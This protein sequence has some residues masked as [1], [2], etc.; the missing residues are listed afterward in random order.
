MGVWERLDPCSRHWWGLT[1][2]TVFSFGHLGTERMLR[3]WSRSKEGQRGLWWAWKICPLRRDWR[4]W[5][6]LVW[7]S[8]GWGETLLVFQYLK[9]A[10]SESGVGLFWLVTGW[11]EM[12][13]SCTRGGL[14]W[15]SGNTSL[16]KGLLSTGMGSPGRCLKTIPG[17]VSKPFWCGAQ[18]HDLAVGC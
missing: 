8:G 10:Y 1:L 16:Q 13:S 7:G 3:C 5:G 11:V 15:I 12:T 4:N 9:G 18:G 2:S 14:G 6:C 17:C